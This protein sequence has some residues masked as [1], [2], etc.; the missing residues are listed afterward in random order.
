MDRSGKIAGRCFS[1]MGDAQ[2]K[3]EY[4]SGTSVRDLACLYKVNVKSIKTS[5]SRAGCVLRCPPKPKWSKDAYRGGGWDWSEKETGYIKEWAGKKSAA[6]IAKDLE[7]PLSGMYSYV[8]ERKLGI[9]FVIHRFVHFICD[10]C[11]RQTTQVKSK[12]DGSTYHYC[13][14]KCVRGYHRHPRR[15]MHLWNTYRLVAGMMD[16]MRQRQNGKC[17][18]CQAPLPQDALFCTVDHIGLKNGRQDRKN[19]RGICCLDGVCNRIA[20]V[21]EK[22]QNPKLDWGMMTDFVGNVQQVLKENHGNLPFSEVLLE[23]VRIRERYKK[24][25]SQPRIERPFIMADSTKRKRGRP[26]KTNDVAI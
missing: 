8:S 21:I 4:E 23:E 24:L 13:S 19:V 2:N 7:R 18:W 16:W 1:N 3:L 10:G 9:S 14:L 11:G 22:N 25:W 5:L 20:G 26:R 15:E 6:E 17:L 12:Y